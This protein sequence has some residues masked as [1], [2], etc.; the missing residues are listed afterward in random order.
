[1]RTEN[2]MKG[3][4]LSQEE[5]AEIGA[6]GEGGKVNEATVQAAFAEIVAGAADRGG[7]NRAGKEMAG[8]RARQ[9]A[10]GLLA[11]GEN[12]RRHVNSVF[13]DVTS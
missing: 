13:T 11:R 1:M 2:E 12:R 3:L 5:A 9:P 6:A 8:G 10:R 7:D 4:Q